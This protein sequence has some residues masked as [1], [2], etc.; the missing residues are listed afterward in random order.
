MVSVLQILSR[1]FVLCML[2]FILIY[3]SLIKKV[4]VYECFVEG[5]GEGFA[6]AVKIIPYLVA[7]MM[8]VSIFKNGGA[9]DVFTNI[10]GSIFTYLNVPPEIFPLA[11]MRPFSG[12]GALGIAAELIN[13]YGPDSLIGRLASTMQGSTDTTFFVLTVYFGSVGVQ[14]YRYAP[15]VGLLAD[16]STFFA[17][18]YIVNRIFT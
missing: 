7:M 9:M 11:L 14:R 6:I 5:A 10:L 18:V 16:F 15:L 8:A 4:K 17:S 13:A 12:G 3:A 1:W 2:L